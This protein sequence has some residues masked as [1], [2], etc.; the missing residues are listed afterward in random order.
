MLMA[1]E[2]WTAQNLAGGLFKWEIVLAE[3]EDASC[4]SSTQPVMV[5]PGE[6]EQ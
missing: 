1:S 5:H 2:Q 3:V 6:M 4:T